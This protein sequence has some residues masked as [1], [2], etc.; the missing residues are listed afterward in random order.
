LGSSLDEKDIISMKKCCKLLLGERYCRKMF[1]EN[2]QLLYPANYNMP[3]SSNVQPGST[4]LH[5]ELDLFYDMSV[6]CGCSKCKD[7]NKNP[8]L[9]TLSHYIND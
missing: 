4:V 7:L 9:V 1:D 5:Y 3:S 8:Q 6:P 2:G